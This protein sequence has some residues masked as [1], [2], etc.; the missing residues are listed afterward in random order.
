MCKWLFKFPWRNF[1][2]YYDND[3]W[4]FDSNESMFESRSLQIS[5]IW[6]FRNYVLVELMDCVRCTWSPWSWP[7]QC[8]SS[9]S[10]IFKRMLYNNIHSFCA[11]DHLRFQRDWNFSW[12]F[13]IFWLYESML[14]SSSLMNFSELTDFACGMINL[15]DSTWRKGKD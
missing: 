5:N 2:N 14:I 8:V 3:V 15:K 11:T 7:F 12:I 10:I 6:V 1:I 4:C 9:F 13:Q